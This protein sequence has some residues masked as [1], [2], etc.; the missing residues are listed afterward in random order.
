[1]TMLKP[2][3]RSWRVCNRH[4]ASSWRRRIALMALGTIMIGSAPAFAWG[5]SNTNVSKKIQ[6]KNFA[7]AEQALREGVEDLKA[8]RIES[9]VAALMYAAKNGEVIARWKLGELY[10]VGDGV[11]RDDS[12]AYQYFSQIVEDYDEDQPNQQD[13]GAISDAFVAVGVYCLNG[14]PTGNVRP[15]P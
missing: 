12:K 9:S 4:C 10:A 13:L 3:G 11:S 2:D 1:M 8:G 6:S 5:G 7:S 14:V 15:D